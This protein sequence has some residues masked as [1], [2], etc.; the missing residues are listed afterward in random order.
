MSL[1][2]RAILVNLRIS[3]WTGR[4]LDKQAT[5]KVES[6]FAT[7]G[8]VG[9]YTKK[10]LP[11]AKELDEVSRQ[12]SSMRNFFY[13]QTLP[14]FSDGSRILP[15][16]NYLDFTSAFRK[17]KA[18]FDLAVQS[19]VDAY[20]RIQL[21][22]SQSLGDLYNGNE[23]PDIAELAHL[24]HC[25]LNAMPLPDI[26]DFRVEIGESERKAFIEKMRETESA[27][28]RDC[29]ER[30]H[31]VVKRATERLADP[32]AVFRDSLL[33]NISEI[34]QLLPKL[35]VTDDPEL[36]KARQAVEAVVNDVTP[37]I[38]R[39]APSTRQTVA[40]DLAEIAAKMSVF[41]GA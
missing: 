36:E 7:R 37:E 15:S 23:Y 5:G 10:L 12:T 6:E 27:A 34:C 9:N 35:N 38:L 29:W 8:K 17:R 16:K 11:G 1:S 32:K 24:F 2:N 22:A 14:W 31:S 20:P 39:E 26:S 21:E 30:L 13:E 19:F 4:K 41:M 18:D 40:D 33:D 28:M 3:Q 25:D